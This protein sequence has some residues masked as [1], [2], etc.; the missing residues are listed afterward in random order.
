MKAGEEGDSQL[1]QL[2]AIYLW[3]GT[4][5]E[6]QWHSGESAYREFFRKKLLDDHPNA[7]KACGLLNTW[8]A[9]MEEVADQLEQLVRYLSL[10]D[11]MGSEPSL[12][13]PGREIKDDYRA[14]LLSLRVQTH[15]LALFLKFRALYQREWHERFSIPFPYNAKLA[16]PIQDLIKQVKEDI[17]D[18]WPEMEKVRE[19]A[20]DLLEKTQSFL[21]DG[22]TREISMLEVIERLQLLNWNPGH[23]W[24][25]SFRNSWHETVTYAEPTQFIRHWTAWDFGLN[26]IRQIAFSSNETNFRYLLKEYEWSLGTSATYFAPDLHFPLVS[27]EL[28]HIFARK[29]DDDENSRFE[30]IGGFRAYGLEDE[31]DFMRTLLNRSGNLL[32]LPKACNRVVSN[33]LPDIKA[34]HFSNCPD[35]SGCSHWHTVSCA[36]NQMS[37]LGNNHLAYRYAVELRCAELALFA[38]QRFFYPRKQPFSIDLHR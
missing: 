23:R 9:A 6:I 18:T 21:P 25:G 38:L 8:I 32:F 28:E 35:Q 30:A 5:S 31:D 34:A 37:L 7:E 17:D 3:A 1:V 33:D 24:H 4:Y 22:D 12:Y 19:Y 10:S 2:I 20:N 26:F 27:L 36:G 14:V 13:Y 16:N 11:N 15:F 29:I